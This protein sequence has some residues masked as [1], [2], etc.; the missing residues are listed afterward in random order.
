MLISRAGSTMKAV[1]LGLAVFKRSASQQAGPK[2]PAESGGPEPSPVK[3]PRCDIDTVDLD[4]IKGDVLMEVPMVSLKGG[5]AVLKIMM[6]D[7]ARA[8]EVFPSTGITRRVFVSQD[9]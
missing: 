7:K 8:R 9:T 6:G 4:D 2:R 3:K 1:R 5:E